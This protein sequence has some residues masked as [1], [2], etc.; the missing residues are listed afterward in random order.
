MRPGG[1]AGL[2]N[3]GGAYEDEVLGLG[4]EVDLGKAADLSL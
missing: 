4:D 3:A 2:A 1:Q